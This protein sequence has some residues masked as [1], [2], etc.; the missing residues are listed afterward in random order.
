MT[1]THELVFDGDVVRKRF[2][3]WSEGE[4]EREWSGLSL[5]DRCAPG[6]APRPLARET[7][8]EPPVIVMS[9]VPG[10]P[11]GGAHLSASQLE[12]LGVA[13]GRLFAV[14]IEPGTQERAW[15]PSTMCA[16]V[17]EWIAGDYDLTPCRDPDL[18]RDAIEA[19]RA[20]LAHDRP[21]L[22]HIVD[23]VVARG[24]GN[25]DNVLWDDD[26]CRLVDFEEFGISDIA[27]EIADVLEH[28]SSRLSRYLDP[29]ALIA[30]FRLTA[31]QLD[32]LIS[33][34][35]LMAGFWL[36]MLLPGNGGFRRNPAGSTEDQATHILALL[37][38]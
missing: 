8:G 11:L 2:V 27:Y 3:S 7:E 29:D 22:D 18:V 30:T 5:L 4:A 16:G 38:G 36:V 12:G 33:Y 14:P 15:G 1:H 24:D 17:R 9:R 35:A 20:W 25:L 31:A 6:L 21:N 10:E 23:P 13:L 26:A 19:T 34:R 28:A 32:R 37:D